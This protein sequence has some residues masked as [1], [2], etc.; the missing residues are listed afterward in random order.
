[1]WWTTATA[2][3]SKLSEQIFAL[4]EAFAAIQAFGAVFA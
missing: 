3:Y 2:E 1:V 4:S